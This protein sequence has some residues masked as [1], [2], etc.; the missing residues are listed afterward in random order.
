MN[1]LSDH[2]KAGKDVR[3]GLKKKD[4]DDLPIT[5]R[6]LGITGAGLGNIIHIHCVDPCWHG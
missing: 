5:N 3:I 2:K 4:Y 6:E 1:L